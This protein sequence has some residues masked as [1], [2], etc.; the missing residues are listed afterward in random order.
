MTTATKPFEGTYRADP[1]H[2]SF[3]FSVRHNEISDYKGTLAAEATRSER[4]GELQLAGAAD[5][6]SISIREP[7][8]FRA[9]VLGEEF[10][11]AAHHPQV[12]FRSTA[13]ELGEDGS[14]H[15]EGELTI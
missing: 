2:S 12:T 14:A 15:I 11:D 6:E 9:H 3:E 8:E 7:E 1:V 5:V 4:D 13:V 10:F